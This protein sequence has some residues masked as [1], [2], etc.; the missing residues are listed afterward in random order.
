M[1]L[2]AVLLLISLFSLNYTQAQNFNF[3]AE[4]PSINIHIPY[5]K[6]KDVT[7][8]GLQFISNKNITGIKAHFSDLEPEDKSNLRIARNVLS[9]SPVTFNTTAGQMTDI[10]VLLNLPKNTT[11]TYHGTVMFSYPGGQLA[12]NPINIFVGNSDLLI[13]VVGLILVAVGVFMAFIVKL[14]KLQFQA[15]DLA[16]EAVYKALSELLN[17]KDEKR[18]D[19]NYDAASQRMDSGYKLLSRGYFDEAR[20]EYE[21]ASTQYK[22][23]KIPAAGY[24]PPKGMGFAQQSA[25]EIV[26]R[27]AQASGK[28][29][30]KSF[31][32]GSSL[33]YVLVGIL[34]IVTIA[35]VWVTVLP[36]IYTIGGSAIW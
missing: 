26:I 33:I 23:A 2:V 18:M 17:A 14:F 31:S 8:Y 4:P 12:R 20:T 32:K 25:D 19:G 22:N 10:D 6:H 5:N 11:G 16:L 35:Q 9:I 7:S 1:L 36:N 30:R 34:L 13:T 24:K 15:R 27:A 28:G 3:Q 21:A 29:I